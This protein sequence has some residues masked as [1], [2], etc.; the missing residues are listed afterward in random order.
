VQVVALGGGGFST[1]GQ[2]TAIDRFVLGLAGVPWPR[3]CFLGTASADDESYYR[4]FEATFSELGAVTSAIMVDDPLVDVVATLDMQHVVYVGS[5]D[6]IGLMAAWRLTG[7]GEA[8]VDAARE[9]VV[10]CGTSAGATCWFDVV[11]DDGSAQMEAG[12]GLVSGAF[13]PHRGE[14][15]K[16]RQYVSR[17]VASGLVTEAYAADEEAALRFVDGAL[18]E[19]LAVESGNAAEHI[20]WTHDGVQVEHLAATAI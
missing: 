6:P 13:V 17:L 15:E 11:L 12:L 10:M 16:H 4:S 20:T 9:D 19:V 2:A 1:H 5:G 3:I 8:L 14:A 7:I 18:V